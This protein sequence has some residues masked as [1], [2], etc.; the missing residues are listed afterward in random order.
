MVS[1]P[2]RGLVR[3]TLRR[4][5]PSTPHEQDAHATRGVDLHIDLT[6]RD[7]GMAIPGRGLVRFT[8]RRVPPTT[9]HEQDGNA[10]VSWCINQLYSLRM[11]ICARCRT[12]TSL[13]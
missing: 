12:P 6:P 2:G 11:S 8:L 7:R 5:P 9:S 13:Q 4:V 3:F 1:H 10:T